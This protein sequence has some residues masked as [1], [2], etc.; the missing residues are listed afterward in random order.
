[1][2]SVGI[3]AV[4]RL[5]RDDRAGMERLYR[6]YYEGA[7]ECDFSRDLAEKH[8]AIVLRGA[9][10]VRGFSTMKLVRVAETNVLFSGDTVVDEACRSQTGLAGAFGHVMRHLAETGVEDPHW[11]LMS[12]S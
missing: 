2:V 9:E 1:M 6:A 8:W 3:W 12:C 4:G 10:G 5:S 7:D 11:F